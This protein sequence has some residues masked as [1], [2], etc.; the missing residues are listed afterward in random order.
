MGKIYRYG[1]P[2]PYLSEKEYE[3]MMKMR[4]MFFQP[5]A[6]I[7]FSCLHLKFLVSNT[8]RREKLGDSGEN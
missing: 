5:A 7:I 4:N 2:V 6:A 8:Q 3:M 1:R